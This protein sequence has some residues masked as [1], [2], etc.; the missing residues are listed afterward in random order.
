MKNSP[1]SYRERNSESARIYFVAECCLRLSKADL[2]VPIAIGRET[3]RE[4]LKR[5]GETPLSLCFSLCFVPGTGVEPACLTDV[6][7]GRQARTAVRFNLPFALQAFYITNA[8][9]N[10]FLIPFL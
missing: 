4:R 2:T 3:V 9:L 1:D 5:E 10:L 8:F 6:S 7:H